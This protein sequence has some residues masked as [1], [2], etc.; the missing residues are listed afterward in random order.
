MKME[1]D[2]AK[3][4]TLPFKKSIRQTI[5]KQ[6]M[7]SVKQKMGLVGL[8]LHLQQNGLCLV[9]QQLI[10]RPMFAKFTS[11]SI[12]ICGHRLSFMCCTADVPKKPS[13]SGLRIRKLL[14]LCIGT[15]ER[16]LDNHLDGF[17]SDGRQH[18][19]VMCVPGQTNPTVN[20][21][22]IEVRGPME[23]NFVKGV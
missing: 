23:K 19:F 4:H 11:S 20:L 21:Y 14:L 5:K 6:R 9:L 12:S 16:L 22:R 7:A 8:W 13:A 18:Y 17:C 1:T 2:E 15:R 10:G 3:M